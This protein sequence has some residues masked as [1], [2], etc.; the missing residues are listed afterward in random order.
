MKITSSSRFSSKFVLILERSFVCVS[1]FQDPQV[2]RLSLHIFAHLLNKMYIA[3]HN[4]H[5]ITF[6][7]K[8]LY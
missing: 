8:V 5:I 3:L 1:S 4:K 2:F 7:C 6:G